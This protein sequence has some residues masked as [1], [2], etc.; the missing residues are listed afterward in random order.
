MSAT[1]VT[2]LGDNLYIAGFDVSGAT[3][4]LKISSAAA[5]IDVT[6]IT[7]SANQRKKGLQSGEMNITSYL[8]TTATTGAHAYYST[9]PTTDAIATYLR[10]TSLGNPMA[11]IQAK[12]L[13]Y[14]FVRATD[15]SLLA[16]I[17]MQSDG[18]SGLQWGFNLTAGWRTDTSATV[19]TYYDLANVYPSPISFPLAYG[20]QAFVQIQAIT[21]TSVN[22]EINHCSTSGGSYSTLMSTGAVA[23]ASAPTA[24]YLNVSNT[25]TVNEYIEITTTGTFS[26]AKF[27]VGLIVNQVAGFTP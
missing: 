22:V 25:T 21:G 10:G 26:N 24:F 4:S 27:Y 7:Q 8:D 19:G 15:G 13:N 17:D 6:D 12:Q 3:Q 11:G 16:S 1:K 9:L 20:A 2:G 18:I 5:T 23:A 14:D